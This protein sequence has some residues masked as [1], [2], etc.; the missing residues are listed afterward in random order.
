M[1]WCHSVEKR[2]LSLE[3]ILR[4]NGIQ[5][6]LVLNALIWQ[7]FHEKIVGIDWHY[8]HTVFAGRRIVAVLPNAHSNEQCIKNCLFMIN[9]PYFIRYNLRCT[10]LMK[11]VVAQNSADKIP[12]GTSISERKKKKYSNN[13]CSFWV[14]FPLQTLKSI[15]WCSANL[16][17]WLVV[18][19]ILCKKYM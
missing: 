15:N 3:I 13:S 12:K 7:N 14:C 17:S 6:N 4:E 1:V 18:Q 2:E 9:A 10:S 5:W 16:Q 19:R 8:F 11:I